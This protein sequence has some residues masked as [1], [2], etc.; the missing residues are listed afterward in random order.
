VIIP[1]PPIPE[2]VNHGSK[3]FTITLGT[4]AEAEGF[5][6][7]LTTIALMVESAAPNAYASHELF[8]RT[9]RGH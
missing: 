3:P 5:R 1:W 8:P 2:V 7:N 6:L 9:P 4:R